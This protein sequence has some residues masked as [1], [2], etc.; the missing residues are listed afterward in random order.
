[1]PSQFERHLMMTYSIMESWPL[2]ESRRWLTWLTSPRNM[3]SGKASA[4]ANRTLP[5][6][7]GGQTLLLNQPNASGRYL[8]RQ[9]HSIP[10]VKPSMPKSR[11]IWYSASPRALSCSLHHCVGDC[12][13]ANT[14]VHIEPRSFVGASPTAKLQKLAGKALETSKYAQ[15]A[16]LF[17]FPSQAAC[18]PFD[19]YDELKPQGHDPLG[20]DDVS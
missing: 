18:S 14:V 3:A 16:C 5:A 1:M 6:Q 17:V 20:M 10:M 4:H 19:A 9:S 11:A 8:R 2:E 15:E 7:R 12:H 13:S